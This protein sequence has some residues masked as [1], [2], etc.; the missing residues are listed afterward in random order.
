MHTNGQEATAMNKAIVAGFDV[1]PGASNTITESAAGITLAMP[2]SVTTTDMIA[3][4]H[5]IALDVTPS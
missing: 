4:Y 3:R 2:S 5:F 1:D